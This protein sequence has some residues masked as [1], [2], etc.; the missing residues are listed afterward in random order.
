MVSRVKRLFGLYVRLIPTPNVKTGKA[1]QAQPIKGL[2]K[3]RIVTDPFSS[4][5]SLEKMR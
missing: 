2:M 3:T 4:P 5:F 1:I